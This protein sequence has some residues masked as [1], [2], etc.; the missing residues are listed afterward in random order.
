MHESGLI[1]NLFEAVE[2]KIAGNPIEQV[3][4]IV[5]QVSL[6]GGIKA[7]HL[8]HHFDCCVQGTPWQNVVLEIIEVPSG[9]PLA[10]SSIEL[11]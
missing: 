10:L 2:E 7:E 8:R 4:K 3:A 5:V 1:E 9:P 6:W 11:V